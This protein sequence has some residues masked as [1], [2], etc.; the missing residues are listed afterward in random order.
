MARVPVL[1][2]LTVHHVVPAPELRR[3]PTRHA[4][5]ELVYIIDGEYRA[6]VG[7]EPVRASTG[8]CCFYPPQARHEPQAFYARPPRLFV[9]QWSGGP[10][11]PPWDAPFATPDPAGRVLSALTWIWNTSPDL[12]VDRSAGEVRR[13]HRA[14]FSAVMREIEQTLGRGSEPTDPVSKAARLIAHLPAYPFSLEELGRHVG[15]SPWQLARRFRER[16]GEPP[17]QYRK[18]LRLEKALHLVRTTR[19]GL[20][21]IAARV[22]YRTPQ[23]LSRQMHRAFGRPPSALRAGAPR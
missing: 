14:L 16:F 4:W 21:E 10:S 5:A 23:H 15:L 17:M 9:A 22:G 20:K 19:L 8:E 3:H 13:L 18:R 11:G 12:P 7:G 1:R 6:A 2:D